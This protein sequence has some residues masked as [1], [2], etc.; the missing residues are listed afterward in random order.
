[1]TPRERLQQLPDFA[2]ELLLAGQRIVIAPLDDH[3]NVAIRALHRTQRAIT[4]GP[5]KRSTATNHRLVRVTNPQYGC[6]RCP[7]PLTWRD[8]Q[9][10]LATWQ[11]RYEY[12]RRKQR[13]ITS[14]ILLCEYHARQAANRYGIRMP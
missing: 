6:S 4:S 13:V 10:P 12:L 3:G 7:D 5:V 1:M 9:R 11:L 2:V 14:G 8:N